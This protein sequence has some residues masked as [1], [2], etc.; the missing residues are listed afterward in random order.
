MMSTAP[1]SVLIVLVAA[2]D[3]AS[4]VRRPAT[5][6]E[7][8]LC[9]VDYINTLT[10]KYDTS[11][12]EQL[13]I[14]YN[15]SATW[16]TEDS[17]EM[18][19][20]LIPSATKREYTCYIE[21]NYFGADDIYLIS[22][23]QTISEQNSSTLECGP[24]LLSNTF[25]PTA[26]F[27]LTVSFSKNYN[28]SWNTAYES[29][30]SLQNGELEY[31]LSYKREKQSWVEQQSIHILEDEKSVVLMQSSF[32]DEEDYEARVRAKPQNTSQIYQGS[33]SEWSSS[34]TWRTQ[35]DVKTNENIQTSY[36][37][38]TFLC[39][40]T[41]IAIMLIL[42]SLKLPQRLWKNVWVFIPDPAPFFKPLY[43]GHNGDFKSWLGPSFNTTTLQFEVGMVHAENLE[44]CNQNMFKH[45]SK[46]GLDGTEKLL[47]IKTCS[48]NHSQCCRKCNS[49]SG[50]RD[51]TFEHIS[52]DFVTVTEEGTPC[53]SHC[54]NNN[55]QLD[56]NHNDD[57][58]KN[59]DDGYPS[60]N[61]DSGNSTL[62]NQLL[63]SE[64][65]TEI[66]VNP[67]NEC[68]FNLQENIMRPNM[69]ILDLISIAPEEWELQ[70]SPSQGDESLFYDEHYNS[71]SPG[72]GNSE[73]FS[74]PR[75]CLD[76]DTIDSGFMDSECGSPV[77]S[78]FGNGD[79]SSKMENLDSYHKQEEECQRNYV[80]QW[81]PCNSTTV[82][83]YNKN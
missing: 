21:M 18:F 80:K 39:A 7:D 53:C 9:S 74:Y 22:I 11:K 8:L 45:A 28:F 72:S 1:V 33:W 2:R 27:N 12:R 42:K 24:F 83:G 64:S 61:I 35:V 77:E 69:N 63:A 76:L 56:E 14:S 47:P 29:S 44:I 79:I 32:Q 17:E 59:E 38:I 62:L 51:V 20:D 37:W 68:T 57:E 52:I 65:N 41:I 81:V 66:S 3:H 10:C 46:L 73:D 70:V 49:S 15:L 19:C 4:G 71:L 54:F 50:I 23:N 25:Q 55:R 48:N 5:C 67:R 13:G 36:K 34:I 43:V 40:G 16:I 31:E 60:V 58:E 75:M 82:G 78:D 6:C 26:P 30:L